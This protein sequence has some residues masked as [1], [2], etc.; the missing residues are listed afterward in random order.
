MADKK[1]SIQISDAEWQVMKVLWQTPGLSAAQVA[2]EV[3]MENNWSDGTIRTYL[4]RLIE[5]GALRFEQDISDS[6]IYY[7]FPAIDEKSAFESESSSFL[8]RIIK[9]K[10][11]IVLA[12]LIEKSELT[13]SEIAELED[14]LKQRRSTR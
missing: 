12:S 11:G 1:K 7:Y 4:R 13:D 6:R 5:K 3:S 10:A 14:I 2:A 8:R 9:G